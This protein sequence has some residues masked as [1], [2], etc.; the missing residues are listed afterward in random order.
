VRGTLTSGSRASATSQITLVPRAPAVAGVTPGQLAVGDVLLSVDGRN[1]DSTCIVT[2]DGAALPTTYVSPTRVTAKGRVAAQA[3]SKVSLGVRRPGPPVQQS[4]AWPMTVVASGTPIVNVTPTSAEV[5]AASEKTFT[6]AIPGSPNH[7]FTW[8]VNGVR[9]GNATIG[10]I[11]EYGVYYAPDLPPANRTVTITATTEDA[12]YRSGTATVTIQN[13]IPAVEALFPLGIRPGAFSLTLAGHGF[14]PASQAFYA[15]RALTTTYVSPRRLTVSGTAAVADGRYVLITVSNPAPGASTSAPVG[16]PI[17][18]D[19]ATPYKATLEE[20]GRLLEQAAFGANTQTLDRARSLGLRTWIDE[21][22]VVAESAYPELPA[23]PDDEFV[24]RAFTKNIISGQDQ[25]RQRT[26][27]ALSELFVVS[28]NKVRDP[29]AQLEW[30]RLLS[31]HAF[32]NYRDL[33]EAVT[34]SPAMGSYL[35]LANSEKPAADGSSSANEN[36]PREVMQLFSIGLVALAP[37]GTVRRDP[38]GNPIPTY[39]QADVK[40]MALAM[41]GWGYPTRP[42]ESPRWPTKAYYVGPMIP[43]D[44]AHDTGEK[45][46]LGAVIPAGGSARADMTAALDIL[47]RHPNVGP[48]VATR[49]IRS[50]VK[51]DPSPAYVQRV[52]AVFADNGRGVR[53]DMKAVLKAILLDDEARHAQGSGTDGKLREPVVY[54]ATVFRALDGQLQPLK[55]LEAFL[56]RDMGQRLLEPPS[57]FNFF[58][59]NFRV[60]DDHVPGPEF[61]IYTPIASVARANFVYRYLNESYTRQIQLDL[62][63]FARLA[64]DPPALVDRVDRTFFHGRMSD[65]LRGVI[66]DAVAAQSPNAPRRSMTALYL[67][68]SSSEYLVQH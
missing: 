35:D 37:D 31:R 14:M 44:A 66:V 59:P 9:G 20:A 16:L 51:S 62:E 38:D 26:I 8:A 5:P 47:A 68:L 12:P 27:L 42:G 32:G 61:Q 67:A 49:L 54:F 13:P 25:L 30:Q 29:R 34:L 41:T 63:P 33:L 55:P 23:K 43:Y 18:S 15:G 53:G 1:F 56:T 58:S 65:E 19:P 48:F 36:Y 57:V 11:S 50:L 7:P 45:H 6:A 3:G 52:A 4:N 21:Q 64:G 46:V 60:G 40:Q 17:L 10:K 24:A 2:L 22:F 39:T 28:A